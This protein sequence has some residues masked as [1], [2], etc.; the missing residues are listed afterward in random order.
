ME[1]TQEST[2]T[3]VESF[4]SQPKSHWS[5]IIFSTVGVILLAAIVFLYL[6]NQKLQNK[7][8]DQQATSTIQNQS[9][10]TAETASTTATATPT[11]PDETAGWKTYINEKY[12]FQIKYPNNPFVRLICPNE[13]LLLIQRDLQTKDVVDMSTCAR[14]GR[15]DFEIVIKDQSTQEPTSDEYFTV[16]KSPT[17]ISGISAQKYK[18]VAN[19][20]EGFPGAGS[21]HNEVMFQKNNYYYHIFASLYTEPYFNQIL[22]TFKFL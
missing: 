3:P 11:P 12:G 20:T 16:T 18:S 7:V 5:V 15:Y 6:Q 9:S 8:I 22:S 4:D 14:D 10:T 19:K 21:Q 2:Q 13:H 1:P 17:T